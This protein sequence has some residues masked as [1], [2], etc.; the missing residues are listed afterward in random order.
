[1]FADVRIIGAL[2]GAYERLTSVGVA[3]T[4]FV[5]CGPA[6]AIARA[7]DRPALVASD[8]WELAAEDGHICV[9]ARRVRAQEF[10]RTPTGV[11]GEIVDGG[12]TW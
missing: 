12:V 5:L 3:P 2:P 11:R 6:V 10:V 1:V 8:E 9:S 7:P 4:R